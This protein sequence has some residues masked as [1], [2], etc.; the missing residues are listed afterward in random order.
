MSE[1]KDVVPDLLQSIQDDFIKDFESRKEI[2]S[3]NKSLEEKKATYK[4]A[5][6]L[7]NEIGDIATKSYQKN[8]TPEQFPDGKIPEEVAKDILNPT[9]K[10]NFDLIAAYSKDVQTNLNHKAGLSIQGKEPPFHQDKVDGL[11]K[12]VSENEVEQGKK[13]LDEPVRTFCRSVV[14]SVIQTNAEFH[15]NLGLEPQ[16]IRQ[17]HGKCCKWCDSLAGKHAY[18]EVPPDVYR[19][20]RYCKCTVEYDPKNGKKLRNVH[21]KKELTEEEQGIIQQR[22]EFS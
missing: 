4:E 7:A 10:Q 22:I 3:L 19:R 13:Y 20:H 9:M 11:V 2:Q 21:T 12:K 16:I 15:H 17:S 1:K 8:I 5:N 6:E 14:D 18:P